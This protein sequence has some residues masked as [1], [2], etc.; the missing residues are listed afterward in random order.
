[1]PTQ[2]R[3]YTPQLKPT[4][5]QLTRGSSY[6]GAVGAIPSRTSSSP[7]SEPFFPPAWG[8]DLRPAGTKPGPAAHP[9]RKRTDLHAP[10]VHRANPYQLGKKPNTLQLPLPLNKTAAI[11]ER[12]YLHCQRLVSLKKLIL[13]NHINQYSIMSYRVLIT[14]FHTSYKM[15]LRLKLQSG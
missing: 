12:G 5:G 9:R 3:I 15:V 7:L 8:A 2:S 4:E 14:L 6:P 11:T 1:M 13:K 10:H